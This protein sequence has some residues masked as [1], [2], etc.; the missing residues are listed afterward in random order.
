MDKFELHKLVCEQENNICQIVGYKDNKKVY[1]DTFNGFSATDTTHV[2][3]ATKSIVSI[4][5]G[6]AI[7]Q[8][9]I[10]SVDQ[11]VLDFFPN[12]KIKRGEKTIQNVAI[13]NL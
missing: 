8:G 10:K 3:S 12:Y 4:L 9:L 7:D 11:K 1:S 13:K 5:I 2:M 6:I